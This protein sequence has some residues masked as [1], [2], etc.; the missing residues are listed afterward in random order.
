MFLRYLKLLALALL[1]CQCGEKEPAPETER[2]KVTK[3]A[4]R[5]EM[6][7]LRQWEAKG[8]DK[9]AQTAPPEASKTEIPIHSEEVPKEGSASEQLSKEAVDMLAAM[10]ADPDSAPAIEV[11]ALAHGYSRPLAKP[12]YQESSQTKV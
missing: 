9:A 6:I 11:A 2:P 8:L 12:Q 1:L 4:S 7:P 10:L 5:E 3:P